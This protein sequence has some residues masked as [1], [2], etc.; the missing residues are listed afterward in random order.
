VQSIGI[1]AFM[2][3]LSVSTVSGKSVARAYRVTAK[4]H[5]PPEF[6][7]FL[8]QTGNPI[9]ANEDVIISRSV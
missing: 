3:V 4:H 9:T 8:Q 7:R 2:F 1:G 5:N 6:S